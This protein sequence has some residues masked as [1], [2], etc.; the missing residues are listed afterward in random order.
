[1]TKIAYTHQETGC[2]PQGQP[3]PSY[4]DGQLDYY[5]SSPTA[6][7][8]EKNPETGQMV[9]LFGIGCFDGTRMEYN[10]LGGFRKFFFGRHPEGPGIYSIRGYQ[11]SKL[12]D[13]TTVYPL[14]ATLPFERQNWK[15]G[16]PRQIWDGR[17]IMTET[18]YGDGSGQ[19]VEVRHVGSDGSVYYYNRTNPGNSSPRDPA[20]IP[21]PYNHW[22]FSKTDERGQMTTYVRDERRRVQEIH[23]PG[24]TSEEFDYNEFNQIVNHRLPSGTWKHYHYVNG[25]LEW[26]YNT[27]DG[28]EARKEYTY[29]DLNRVRTMRDGRARAHGA[30]YSVRL[31]YNGRHQVTMEEYPATA[32]SPAASRQYEFDDYGNCIAITNELGHRSEYTYDSYRRCTAYIEPLQAPDWA[33]GPDVP[34]RRWDWIYDRYIDGIGWR[35]PSSH[36]SRSWRIQ[37]EPGFNHV[38]E[39]KMTNRWHDLNDQVVLEQTGWIQSGSLPLGNWY[40]GP[41]IETHYFSYDENGQKKSFTDPRGRV[42]TYDYDGRNRLWKTNETVNTAPRTTETL[43]DTTGNKTMVKFPMEAAG[44]RTQQWLDYDAF[45]QPGRFID[46]RNNTT[47]LAYQWGPMKKL[48]SVI[49]SRDKDGGGR[50]SQPTTFYYDLMGRP[51]TT[52]FPDGSEEWSLYQ[53][54]QLKYFWNRKSQLKTI[55]YDARGREE[56]HTWSDGTPAISRTWDA[57][58]R[59]ASISNSFSSIDF[60]YDRAGQLLWEGNH[61]TGSGERRQTTYHRYPDGNLAHMQYP[62]GTWI[63]HDYTARGQLKRV[64]DHYWGPQQAIEY[65][66][67]ADGKMWYQDYGNGVRASF[68]YD[69]RGF[70]EVAHNYRLSPYGNLSHRTY[71]R[72]ERDRIYAYQKHTDNSLNGKENGRGNHYRYDA[73]GQ[74]TSAWYEA[75]D[76]ANTYDHCQRQD[77]FDY[78]QMGTRRQNNHLSRWGWTWFLRRDNGLNQYL[79]WSGTP[80]NYEG[81]GDVVYDGWMSAT[82]NALNQPVSMSSPTSN[83]TMWFGY[84]PLGR[85]VKRWI[86][87]SGDPSSNPATYLYYNGWNLIQEGPSATSVS[88]LYIHGG[89]VDEIVKQIRG[90]DGWERFFQHDAQGNCILQTD[91][92]GNL[93]E[94]YDYDAFGQPYFYD[95]AGSDIGGSPWGNRFLFTGREW[96]HDLWIYDYR[97][98]MY[99][100]ELGRFLQPDPIQ[101]K[102]GDYN[103]Y[104]YCHN[105]PV[106]KTDPTGLIEDG[107]GFDG[108]A[109]NGPS[110]ELGPHPLELFVADAISDMVHV[111]RQNIR[112]DPG[113]TALTVVTAGRSPQVKAGLGNA[114]QPVVRVISRTAEVAKRMAE[115]FFGGRPTRP[116]IDR[117]TGNPVGRISTDGTRVV[118]EPHTDSKTPQLH[119]NLEDKDK[120]TNIHVIIKP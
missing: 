49:T 28:W 17:G 66:Y 99:H 95:A 30:E 70:T 72:D 44:Q 90:S 94:Q 101:F 11:L 43:Y 13:F 71:Y 119:W 42:T 47:D 21:N 54:G 37:V 64:E 48:Q 8:E 61:I 74:L 93:V 27:T 9:S 6:I 46:E 56:S 103:L 57:A 10:G 4:P 68:A 16:H 86:G 116:I 5:Y 107:G 1:M 63:R 111:A 55:E 114:A 97:H 77:H 73:E 100:P 60:G 69:A 78:D 41:D 23:H 29:D 58:N 52:V 36:T 85:C 79:D 62:N 32:T 15:D 76:P 45:G 19:P 113:G 120:K 83:G 67:L 102:A 26:E 53:F 14:P 12:T 91:G 84:D 96:L 59:L 115:K 106:N 40:P 25:L 2:R 65:H 50:E 38:G 105:D 89:R 39:R 112:N 51:Q 92:A 81:N 80:I 87:P 98:R 117:Q 18:V 109:F 31:S 118:R 7:K 34:S 75:V 24:D 20:R 33:G 35:P 110:R 104:R 88:M 108:S 22:L 3:L 82:Y